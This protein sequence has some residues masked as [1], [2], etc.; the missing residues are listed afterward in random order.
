MRLHLVHA[1]LVHV[2]A[3][4]LVVGGGVEAAALVLRKPGIARFG[5]TLVLLGALALVPTLVAGIVAANVLSIPPEAHATLDAHE[6][7]AWILLGA[8]AVLVIAKAWVRGA[9]PER[10]RLPYALALVATVA[11]TIWTAWLGAALVYGHG[12]GVGV[13]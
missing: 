10:L 6:R 9:V 3:A 13:G 5:G 12:V 2:P 8:A 1:A 4:F 11:L 7:N